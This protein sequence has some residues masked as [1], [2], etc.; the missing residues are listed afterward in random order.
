LKSGRQ[1]DFH[2]TARVLKLGGR[3]AYGTAECHGANSGLLAHHVLTY[4]RAT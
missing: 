4:I 1:E 2:C 3:S